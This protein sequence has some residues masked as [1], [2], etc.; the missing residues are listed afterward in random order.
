MFKK[1]DSGCFKNGGPKC[2]KE[3]TRVFEVPFIVHRT[4]WNVLRTY[5]IEEENKTLVYRSFRFFH[6]C[7]SKKYTLKKTQPRFFKTRCL[8]PAN[9]VGIFEHLGRTLSAQVP[10]RKRD[11]GRNCS[12]QQT[13]RSKCLKDP[14]ERW[15][16]TFFMS[17]LNFG[18]AENFIFVFKKH[19]SRQ[20]T[21][22]KKG[23]MSSI[24]FQTFFVFPP[25]SHALV[26]FCRMRSRRLFSDSLMLRSKYSL[27]PSR[28]LIFSV[29]LFCL[30]SR[31]SLT[32]K[33]K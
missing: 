30:L 22:N 13:V 14:T 4:N 32:W 29:Q 3:P 23:R 26:F 6:D 28:V 12:M 19:T 24:F 25:L 33:L 10:C 17:Y 5:K 27:F 16:F 7:I 15:K 9:W 21:C 1:P 2:S 8:L 31:R 20:H 11:S 18:Q